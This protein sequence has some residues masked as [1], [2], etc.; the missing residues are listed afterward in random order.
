MSWVKQKL[1]C[2]ICLKR[3]EIDKAKGN[4]LELVK[5]HNSGTKDAPI[6]LDEDEVSVLPV[7]Q[8]DQ[9]EEKACDLYR[10]FLMFV[11]HFFKLRTFTD[12]L[13]ACAKNANSNKDGDA[14][15]LETFCEGCAALVS[16]ICKLYKE[17]Q[18][19]KLLLAW[20]LSKVGQLIRKSKVPMSNKLAKE[21]KMSLKKQMNLDAVR[22]VDIFRASLQ[23]KC[24]HN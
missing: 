1:V 8:D 23:V 24:K 14:V 19:T 16:E 2:I 13:I 4:S 20:K 12:R 15:R 3:F 7:Q 6:L 9:K 11:S 5:V 22:P 18:T 21:L 10:R 17:I